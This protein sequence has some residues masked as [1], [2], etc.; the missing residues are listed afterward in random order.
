M[1]DA[2]SATHPRTESDDAVPVVNIMIVLWRRRWTIAAIGLA[3]VVGAGIWVAT[4]PRTYESTATIVAPRE[5]TGSGVLGSLV[6]ASGLLQQMP[7]VSVPSLTSNR[8]LLVSVLK[9][10]TMAQLVLEQFGLQARYR[11]RYQEDAVKTLQRKTTISVNREGVIAVKTEDTDPRIA[12]AMANFYVEKL[13]RLLAQYNLGEASRERTFLTEQLARAR[14]QLDSSEEALRR[15]QEQNRAIVLQ[16][17]TRGAIEVAARLRGEIMAA[18]VQAQVMRNFATEANPEVIALRRR[19]DEMNRQLT[20][21][22]YGETRAAAKQDRRDFTVPVAR[23]PEVGLEL[24]RLTRE[25]KVQET[26]V[27]LL[28]QQVEQIRIVEAKDL[29][30]AQVLDRAVP[31]ERPARPRLAISLGVAA[32]SGLFAGAMC[33]LVMEYLRFVAPRTRERSL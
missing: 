30:A 12:A 16:E 23:V 4:T 14:A 2:P 26:L 11:E 20:Q 7:A 18:E 32:I 10:R 15:F 9:S 19:I 22:Q 24:V 28:T 27:T 17:Q 33:A 21:L 8:D 6:V 1:I 31:A 25:V 5:P 13:E 29:P 3:A